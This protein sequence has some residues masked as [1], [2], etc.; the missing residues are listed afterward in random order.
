[1]LN[2]HGYSLGEDTIIAV[3]IVKDYI[4]KCGGSEKVPVTNALLKSCKQARKKYHTDLEEKR[5]Q[6]EKE[7]SARKAAV[8]AAAAL[9]AN[10]ESERKKEDDVKKIAKEIKILESGMNIA[11]QSIAEANKALSEVISKS[12]TL[13]KTKLV[14]EM[15]KAQSKIEMG[16]KRKEQLSK[17]M[18]VV[19]IKKKKMEE[20]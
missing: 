18:E 7:E 11:E 4:I 8:E 20:K 16:M 5:R 1:M 14:D 6:A 13:S 15:M 17:D 9:E 12:V 10:K 19:L 2:I 3:R